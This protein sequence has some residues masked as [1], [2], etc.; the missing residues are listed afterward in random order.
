MSLFYSK[1]LLIHIWIKRFHLIP[2]QFAK[3]VGICIEQPL[4][5]FLFF[6]F[7]LVPFQT[8][9]MYQ[10]YLIIRL[11]LFSYYIDLNYLNYMNSSLT[12][13]SNIKLNRFTKVDLT[14]TFSTYFLYGL[15]QAPIFKNF[16][17]SAF[18]CSSA[19]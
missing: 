7:Q 13:A 14:L 6:V 3:D 11:L 15:G 16:L 8:F 18:S 10:P 5:R 17:T 12:K 1:G 9:F 4:D 2:M 19:G